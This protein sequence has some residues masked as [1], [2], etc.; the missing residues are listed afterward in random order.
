MGFFGSWTYAEGTW[1]PR[2]PG[3]DPAPSGNVRRWLSIDIHDSD[4]TTVRF[5]PAWPGTGE[6]Y[7]GCTPR[8]YFED[9]SASAPTDP[10]LEAG[11]L[12]TW[13]AAE[14]GGNVAA[15]TFQIRPFLV[16]DEEDGDAISA[17]D[18]PGVV[19]VEVTTARFL[20][21]IGL[22]PLPG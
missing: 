6:A 16:A 2:E 20:A 1:V 12:A 9:P 8:D 4:F 17:P 5:Q 10:D 15:L 19:F 22:P 21:T 14:V 11:G 13:A 18:H 7:L 3:Q